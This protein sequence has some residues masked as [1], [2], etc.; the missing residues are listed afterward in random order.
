MAS[1]SGDQST[2]AGS[3]ACRG[4]KNHDQ[5][6]CQDTFSSAKHPWARQRFPANSTDAKTDDIVLTDRIELH[7]NYA[8]KVINLQYNIACLA[9]WVTNEKNTCLVYEECC[10]S[11]LP[12]TD[13]LCQCEVWRDFLLKRCSLKVYRA[14][15]SVVLTLR[16]ICVILRSQLH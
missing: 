14:S 6:P 3:V 11:A 8:F 10:K 7:N 1:S 13:W 16:G 5:A 9:L 4:T 2:K 15:P 12:A